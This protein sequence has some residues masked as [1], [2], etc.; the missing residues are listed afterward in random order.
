MLAGE[1]LRR[2]ISIAAPSDSCGFGFRDEGKK[3]DELYPSF[4]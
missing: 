1:S 3:L 4:K 2:G